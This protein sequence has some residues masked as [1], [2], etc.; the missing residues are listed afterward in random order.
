MK[1]AEGEAIAWH[2]YEVLNLTPEKTRRLVFH[3]ITK[4]AILGAIANPRRLTSRGRRPA[5]T[6]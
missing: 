3:E 4:K 2:L 5:G 1:T 6:P